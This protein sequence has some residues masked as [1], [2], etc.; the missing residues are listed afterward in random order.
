MKRR[1][2]ISTTRAFTLIE[3]ML[4]IG[5]MA[6]LAGAVGMALAEAMEQGREQRTQAQVARIHGLLMMKYDSYR[7]R[8]IRFPSGYFPVNA[9][10]IVRARARLAAIRE[11][12]RM[13]M[14]E[15]PLDIGTLDVAN[16]V[17]VPRPMASGV[18]R[19]AISNQYVRILTQNYQTRSLTKRRS[20][21]FGSSKL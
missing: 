15:R 14:P 18:A 10:A 3:L 6:I 11:I 7:T 17:V 9:N 21:L 16:D 12:M 1:V 4:V 5:M 13:E 19:P 8:S 2:R 20:L